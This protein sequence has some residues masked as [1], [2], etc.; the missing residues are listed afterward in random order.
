M[1]F[2]ITKDISMVFAITKN[3]NTVF[4][5]TEAYVVPKI[6]YTVDSRLKHEHLQPFTYIKLQLIFITS[7]I[8]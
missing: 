5:I 2:A 3:I 1:V 6:L 4:A 8:C 7:F